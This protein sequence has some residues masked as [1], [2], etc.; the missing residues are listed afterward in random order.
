MH[1]ALPPPPPP[2][3]DSGQRPPGSAALSRRG[4]AAAE[5][6]SALNNW[7][8]LPFRASESRQNVRVILCWTEGHT[9]GKSRPL[10]LSE[11]ILGS[12]PQRC[13]PPRD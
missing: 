2:P 3:C 6:S 12:Q 8:P 5:V 9:C 13:R 7:Q 4:R 11:R 1:P 10:A